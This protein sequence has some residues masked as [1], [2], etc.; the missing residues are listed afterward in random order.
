[1]TD[2]AAH[3]PFD[4][5]LFDFSGTLFTVE[6]SLSWLRNAAAAAGVTI[7][8]GEQE[9]ILERLITAGR[10]GGPEPLAIPAAVAEA[11]E[12][13]DLF[14]T[15]HRL[16]YETIIASAGLPAPGL[17]R[18]LYERLFADDGW[19]PYADV[20]P[21]LRALRRR[22][23]R[24]AVLSNIGWDLRPQIAAHGMGDLFDAYVF[25]FEVGVVKPDPEIFT[26]ACDK[27]GVEPWRALMVGDHAADGGAVAVGIR[28]LLLPPDPPG[29]VHGLAAILGLL[30]APTLEERRS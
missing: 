22:G 11:Y 23:I 19:V 21:V 20:L 14:P 27:L 30:D 7:A 24:T 29:S 4:A 6:P 2:P 8:P 17:A 28:S 13:R 12:R 10:P 3:Q 26:I 25:S 16:A 5:V 18:A 15:D 1:M 9:P